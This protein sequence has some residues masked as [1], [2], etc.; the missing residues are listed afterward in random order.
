MAKYPLPGTVASQSFSLP[1]GA[2][3]PRKRS[4]LPSAFWTSLS[5]D[6]SDGKG[7]PLARPGGV[8]GFVERHG[9]EVRGR[10]VLRHVYGSTEATAV[11]AAEAIALRVLADRLERSGDDT[12]VSLTFNRATS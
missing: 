8:L 12:L 10:H 7:W 5:R 9:P 6:P 4:V 1:S 2:L 11:V 3:G